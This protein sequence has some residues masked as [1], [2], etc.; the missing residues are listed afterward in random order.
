MEEVSFELGFHSLLG[1]GGVQ[2]LGWEKTFWAEQWV[3]QPGRAWF[4]REASNEFH[5]EHLILIVSCLPRREM[6]QRLRHQRLGSQ[7][8]WAC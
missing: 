8:A 3:D 2:K 4:G 7:A 5:K 6:V 1:L